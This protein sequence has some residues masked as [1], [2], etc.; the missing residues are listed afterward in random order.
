[1]TDKAFYQEASEELANNG[2]DEALW[3]LVVAQNPEASD[4]VQR[5]KYIQKRANELASAQLKAKV[6]RG[7]GWIRKAAI[8]LGVAGAIG[9]VVVLVLKQREIDKAIADIPSAAAQWNEAAR[10][11]DRPRY[12]DALHRVD[13]LCDFVGKEFAKVT[14]PESLAAFHLCLNAQPHIRAWR[15]WQL[16]MISRAPTVYQNGLS[17]IDLVEAPEPPYAQLVDSE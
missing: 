14:D 6:R 3:A 1:M 13:H 8:G 10:N 12:S 11:S 15:E 4:A 9:V 5:A 16:A 17:R 2:R 7:F